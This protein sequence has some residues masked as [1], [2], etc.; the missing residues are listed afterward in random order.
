MLS[1][2]KTY[3]AAALMILFAGGGIA[4]GEIEMARAGELI[5]EALAIM[6]LRAGIAKV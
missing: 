6:G 1:G 5:I 3:L 4:L 2:N